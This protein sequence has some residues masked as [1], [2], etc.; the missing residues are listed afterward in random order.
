[1][2]LNFN[3]KQKP[4]NKVLKY[5]SIFGLVLMIIWLYVVL[6]L[7]I[8]TSS[9]GI[10][11]QNGSNTPGIWITFLALVGASIWLYFRGNSS[12]NLSENSPSIHPWIKTLDVHRLNDSVQLQLL[13]FNGELLLMSVSQS[14]AELLRRMDKQDWEGEELVPRTQSRS[15]PFGELI[16]DY[17]KSP[18]N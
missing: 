15:E 14:N 13:E 2:N 8:P 16:Q 17:I 10:D 4:N 3:A 18:Q 1:M 11:G 7:D 12:N 9:S 6:Q 5:V